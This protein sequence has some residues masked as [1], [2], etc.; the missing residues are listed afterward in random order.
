MPQGVVFPRNQSG[1]RLDAVAR[2][3][4]PLAARLS[5]CRLLGRE[6]K[7]GA[8]AAAMRGKKFREVRKNFDD[9]AAPGLCF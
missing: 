6:G 7:D 5:F 9:S 1:L 2:A 4:E 3:F 8:G